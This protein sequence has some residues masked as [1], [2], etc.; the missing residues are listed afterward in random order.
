MAYGLWPILLRASG[1]DKYPL[2]YGLQLSGSQTIR[3][4]LLN[5]GMNILHSLQF[6]VLNSYEFS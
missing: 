3:Y 4:N 2:A 5:S 1:M 6:L